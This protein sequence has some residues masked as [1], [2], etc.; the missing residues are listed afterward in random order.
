MNKTAIH[1][2]PRYLQIANHIAENIRSGELGAG[3]QL[4]TERQLAEELGVSR[5]TVRQA[6]GVLTEQGLIKSQHGIGNFVTRP[7]LEQPVDILVGFSDNMLKKGI[8]PSARL[9]DLKATGADQLLAN[10]FQIPLGE[11]VFAIRRL[12]LA[13][14]MPAALEYSY[15][16]QRYVPGL[17]QHDLERRSIYAILAEEYNI[18]LAGAVQTLEPVVALA[19][20]AKL[21]E[22]PAGAPLMLVTRSSSDTRQRVVEFAKDLYRGD[23]FRFVSHSKPPLE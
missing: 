11:P 4:P 6:L 14:K 5:M 15:F 20:Q 16:P 12:R 22:I 23:C 18:V 3:D 8:Q 17:D 2:Q 13:D 7:M 19:Y 21:L 9:L 1:V 10:E